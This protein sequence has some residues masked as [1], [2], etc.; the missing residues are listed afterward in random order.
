MILLRKIFRKIT[1]N[2]AVAKKLAKI[3]CKIHSF[4]YTQLGYFATMAEPDKLHPKHRLTKY[5]QFFLNNIT[6]KDTVLDIGCGNGALSN[7]LAAKAKK[8]TGIDL[9]QENID[10]ANKKFKIPNLEFICGDATNTKFEHHFDIIVLSNVLEHIKERH[11]LLIALKKISKSFLIRVPQYDRAWDVLYKHEL[12]LD[13][14]LDP[15]HET[16]YTFEQLEKELNNAGIK[17]ISSAT[18]FGEFWAV[19]KANEK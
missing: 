10:F 6:S 19:A 5:H 16:E 18:K 12:G 13:Y 1:T 8:V 11:Q 15:T 17:I 4:A 14:R 2:Q 9:I 7:D 3:F